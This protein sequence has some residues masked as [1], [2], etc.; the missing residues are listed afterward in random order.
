[1]SC[2]FATSERKRR[3]IIFTFVLILFIM[4]LFPG[5]GRKG[6][7]TLKAYEPPPS[8]VITSALH[9]EGD[10]VIAWSLPEA[11]ESGISSF[12]ILRSSGTGFQK[13]GRAEN[14]ARMFIDRDFVE[15]TGFEYKLIAISSFDIPSRDSNIVAMRPS[16]LPPPP[17]AMTFSIEKDRVVIRWEASAAR[18]N[19]YKSFDKGSFGPTPLNRAPISV[20]S[21]NDDLDIQ[22]PAHYI[23]R[24]LNAAEW[25]DEGPPSSV[26][27]V[28]PAD[29]LPGPPEEASFTAAKEKIFLYWK[30]A[31][32]RWVRGYRIYRKTGDGEYAL[33]GETQVPT[34]I[35][36][37]S[38]QAVRSYRLHSVGPS[39]EGPGTEIKDIRY[40]PE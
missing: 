32:E 21:Y 33:M 19:I 22:R 5:C 10:I 14:S 9:R 26:L 18:Y 31:Q 35:D 8:P 15:G 16:P 25:W 29:L 1:M 4:P 38:P 12:D 40:L 17:S 36:Q 2:D 6:P 7:P 3:L 28:D 30:P 11:A 37:E 24:G 27:T 13:I 20:P 23:I 39:K 34:F